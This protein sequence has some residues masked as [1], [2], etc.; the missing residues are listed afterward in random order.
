M[1]CL[2]IIYIITVENKT[3]I[4]SVSNSKFFKNI[5]ISIINDKLRNMFS[6]VV[7]IIVII[8]AVFSLSYIRTE[9]IKKRFTI[10]ISIFVLSIIILIYISN[11][12][13]IIIG[14]DGLGL[15]SFCLVIFFQN[16]EAIKSGLITIF[17]NRFGDCLIVSTIMMIISIKIIKITNRWFRIIIL[18][19]TLGAFTKSAQIPFSA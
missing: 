19:I 9:K 18:L 1:V 14:W 12:F 6:V 5:E 10:L 4:I 15:S 8:V 16:K 2:I 17:T 13:S 11:L 7:L 3:I